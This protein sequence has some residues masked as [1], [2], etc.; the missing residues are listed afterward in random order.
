MIAGPPQLPARCNKCRYQMPFAQIANADYRALLDNYYLGHF[1]EELRMLEKV[2]DF[3]E[4]WG[5]GAT[6]N[7][8]PHFQR[9]LDSQDPDVQR[10]LAEGVAFDEIA[11]PPA[12]E[13]R[14]N[15]P[16]DREVIN[17]L[18]HNSFDLTARFQF[19]RER[20]S[21]LRERAST[22]LCP[23]CAEG[24]LHLVESRR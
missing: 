17:Y 13:P 22:V 8:V 16:E 19:V 20:L 7:I 11:L 23:R 1:T 21:E 4:R 10:K 6:T 9:V 24:H 5:S 18:K 15:S 12:P 2:D 14:A 3:R